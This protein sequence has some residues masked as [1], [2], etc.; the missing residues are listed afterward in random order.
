M[1]VAPEWKSEAASTL[2][3]ATAAV[4]LGLKGLSPSREMR[5]DFGGPE[6]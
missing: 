5:G 6:R 1:G 4:S 3:V 2:S